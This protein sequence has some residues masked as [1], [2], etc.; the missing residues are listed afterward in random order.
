MFLK[1]KTV[2][3]KNYL[4][5]LFISII[6]FSSGV[7]FHDAK[8]AYHLKHMLIKKSVVSKNFTQNFFFNEIAEL[9]IDIPF[10]TLDYLK[11]NLPIA[12]KYNDINEAENK[13]KPAKIT[14]ND[15]V[16]KSKIR[17]KGLTNFHRLGNKKSLK[18]KISKQEDG[19][20]PS[21]LGI[22]RFNLMDP[23]RRSNEREWLFRKVAKKEGLIERRYDFVKVKING[24][25][26]GIYSIEE[27]FAKEFF[28]YNKIKIAPIIG[29]DV[30]KIHGITK[31]TDCC[32]HIWINDF[33]FSPVQSGKK[34]Y[35]DKNFNAQYNYAKKNLIEFLSGNIKP[36]EII[37][38]EKFAKFLALGDIFGGWHGNETSNLKLYFNPYNKLL[39]PIPDDM[40]D[41][42]RDKPSR[43]FALFKIRNIGGYSVFYEKLFNSNNFLKIYYKYLQIYSDEKFINS[44]LKEYKNELSLIER[45]I[46]KDD[47][48]FANTIEKRLVE[49]SRT[50]KEFIN[51]KYPVEIIQ[52]SKDDSNSLIIDLQ[53]NFYFP[54][55]LKTSN[56]ILDANIF[57]DFELNLF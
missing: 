23:K 29:F 12:I 55:K 14:F 25:K 30:D 42:P 26:F 18:I 5:I 57:E 49:N 34:I 15:K 47:L 11:K 7:F 40:F 33:N 51:P 52:A 2:F 3:N 54:I 4:I 10:K 28:E 31:F 32:G 19:L 16:Y 13:Y 48:Y 50:I 46:A 36:I 35:N 44:V 8:L 38:L 53:N 39:E 20:I 21:I 24:D 43:D 6:A 45:K 37:D 22:S 41:E 9:K 17:L 1:K 27:N 56:R